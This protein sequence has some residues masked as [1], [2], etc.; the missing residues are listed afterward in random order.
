MGSVGSALV[1]KKAGILK[2]PIGIG[3]TLA[4]GAMGAGLYGAGGAALGAGTYGVKRATGIAK[5]KQN[6]SPL[7]SARKRFGM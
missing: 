1:A 4:G 2:T 7:Q 5:P 3:G 6:N